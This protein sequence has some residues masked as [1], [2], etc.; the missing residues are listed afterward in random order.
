MV[1]LAEVYDLFLR[2]WTVV[3]HPLNIGDNYSLVSYYT[4]AITGKRDKENNANSQEP[5]RNRIQL[6]H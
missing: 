5:W 3:T 6:I 2:N 1:L 4:E